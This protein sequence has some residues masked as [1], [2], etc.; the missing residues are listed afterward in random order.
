MATVIEPILARMFG[1]AAGMKLERR[2]VEKPWGRTAAAH[3]CSIRRP[4]SASERS[5]SRRRGSAAARQISLHQRDAFRSKSTL[6][7]SRPA[8]AGLP[9][10]KSECWYIL[11]AEPEP[12]S[13]LGLDARSRQRRTTRRCA[14][15]L[16]RA[17]DGLAARTRR[18]FLLCSARHYPCDRRAAFRCWSSS[19]MS[20]VTY[21]LYDYGRPRELHLDDGMAV[22][23]RGALP[24]TLAQHLS[25]IGAAD[26]CR[27][28]A[29][30]V[31]PLDGRRAAGPAALGH[32]DRGRSAL[33]GE[34]VGPGD[35]L[36]LEPGEHLE[37]PGARVLIGATA[38]P[39]LPAR[40]RRAARHRC[41]APARECKRPPS[42]S[43][44]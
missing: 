31:G 7:T 33:R 17:V 24:A 36:L 43:C 40:S 25:G 37:T 39:S 38:Q 44:M 5:G 26:A 19:R 23:Q 41:R 32:S 3:R 15:W 35:C 16:D 29:L 1:N 20:D 10:G 30:Y 28:A 22:S 21:R 42:G 27:W 2:Y 8:P 13:A 9:R 4:A 18:R 12:L 14:R 6:T 34:M 11:E